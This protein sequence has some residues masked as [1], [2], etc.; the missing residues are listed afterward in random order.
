MDTVYTLPTREAR[1]AHEAWVKQSAPKFKPGDRVIFRRWKCSKCGNPDDR[2]GTVEKVHEPP[3]WE[4]AGDGYVYVRSYDVRL[5]AK[6]DRRGSRAETG[7]Y[8]AAEFDLAPD[9]EAEI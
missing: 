8:S 2:R 6:P 3:F 1:L 7:T 5:D 4:R 9:Q